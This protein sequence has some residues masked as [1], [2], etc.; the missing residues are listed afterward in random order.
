MRRWSRVRSVVNWLNLTTPAGL[1][2]TGLADGPARRS[3]DGLW[4]SHGYRPAFPA[5]RAFTLGSVILLRDPLPGPGLDPVGGVPRRL[6]AHEERHATQYALCGGLL[7]PLGY[8]VAAGWSW[9][10]TGDPA[11]R[12]PFERG[13]G[14]ADGGYQEQPLRGR[15]AMPHAGGP[16]LRLDSS[17]VGRW[18]RL[19]AVSTRG[20]PYG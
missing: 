18:G 1:L 19:S 14:L 15:H 8:A 4:I 10:A 20:A 12:N 16:C 5:A 3:R 11:S 6:L 13:A 2:A 7:M 17:A 9:L